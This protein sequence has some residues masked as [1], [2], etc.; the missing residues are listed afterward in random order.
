MES[1]EFEK[2]ETKKK[3]RGGIVKGH[4]KHTL[5]KIVSVLL[6]ASL[7]SIFAGCT[8]SC[9]PD[10]DDP[11]TDD[12]GIV[13]P[14][15]NEPET[16]DEP[17][18]PDEPENP[19]EPDDPVIDPDDPVIDPDDPVIDPDDPVIDPDPSDPTDPD[20]PENPGDPEIPGDE[21]PEYEDCKTVDDILA[22]NGNISSFIQDLNNN[23]L[24]S[25]SKYLIGRNGT[26]ESFDSVEWYVANI[27][28][29]D[30]NGLYANVY[31]T[32][33]NSKYFKVG[34]V[35]FDAVDTVQ[36]IINGNLNNVTYSVDYQNPQSSFANIENNTDLGKTVI[37]TID[38]DNTL[39]GDIWCSI[40]G[41]MASGGRDYRII[42][43]YQITENGVEKYEL[44][45]EAPSADPA[46]IMSNIQNGLYNK[47]SISQ[48]TE[49]TFAGEKIEQESASSQ[50]LANYNY[51]FDDEIELC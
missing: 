50:N 24:D 2:V 16:P 21:V 47:S 27:S 46:S 1:N 49:Y 11:S 7:L 32:Q 18:I 13:N 25:L 6:V 4:K 48:S 39:E 12:P 43:V 19:D 9:N 42:T 31:Y 44:T 40:G 8:S 36:D 20:D 45:A 41:L 28:N 35:S 30:I 3:K 23:Y 14:L 5:A 17:E 33:G 38:A 10:K 37:Q 26:A 51:Y 15:P 22:S 34:K 29:N